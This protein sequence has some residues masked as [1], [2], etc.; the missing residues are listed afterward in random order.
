[1]VRSICSN[2][3]CV[4]RVQCDRGENEANGIYYNAH[5]IKII[6]MFFR[7]RC[8]GHGWMSRYGCKI[9]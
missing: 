3:L 1:M 6:I 8:S 7:R 4:M 9:K 5:V 2:I